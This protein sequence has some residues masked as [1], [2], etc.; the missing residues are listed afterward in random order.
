[1]ILASFR[2]GTVAGYGVVD[3]VKGKDQLITYFVIVD[4]SLAVHD[5]EI[6]AYREAYG[7]EVRYK[8]WQE[9]FR[10]KRPGDRLRA[11]RDIKNITGATI[12]A[13]SVTLGV[14][15]VLSV[16]AVVGDRLPVTPMEAR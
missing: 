8:S 7:G 3:N 1:V 13:R 9:Q 2:N 16:L 11:G 12:S 10:G 14:E 4:S 5:L 15:K 6:L